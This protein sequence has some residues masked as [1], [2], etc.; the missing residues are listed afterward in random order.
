[1]AW[2]KSVRA[3]FKDISIPYNFA[4][5]VSFPISSFVPKPDGKNRKKAKFTSLLLF[6][7]K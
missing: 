7:N 6:K 5:T 1:M 3:H 2:L 4:A